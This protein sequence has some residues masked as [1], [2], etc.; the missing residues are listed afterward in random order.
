MTFL[1]HE[2]RQRRM[3]GGILSHAGGLVHSATLWLER[4]LTD[5]FHVRCPAKLIAYKQMMSKRVEGSDCMLHAS[6]NQASKSRLHA[7]LHRVAILDR[8]NRRNEAQC[9]PDIALTRHGQ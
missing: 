3:R 6:A 4:C 8:R 2:E 5:D 9:L 1:C 7:R